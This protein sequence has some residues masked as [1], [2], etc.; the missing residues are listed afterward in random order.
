ML[1][2]KRMVPA[3]GCCLLALGGASIAGAT[4]AA[5]KTVKVKVGQRIVILFSNAHG[6]TEVGTS[7]GK[8]GGAAV[9][10]ALRAVANATG[11]TGFTANGTL[12]Y[13]AG[14][15]RYHLQGTEKATSGGLSLSGTGTFTGGT[16]AYIGARGSFTVTGN[17][18]AN[19]F[20]TTTITGRVALR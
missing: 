14:T 6:I 12:F 5:K 18:P 11:G 15:L 3:L 16:G 1:N 7:D 2:T 19:S 4:A 13:S 8:I 9:H 17:K 20:Q 10:G